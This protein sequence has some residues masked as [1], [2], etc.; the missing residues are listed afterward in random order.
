MQLICLCIAEVEAPI[1]QIALV[2]KVTIIQY[3]LG[4]KSVFFEAYILKILLVDKSCR[5][6]SHQTAV[7]PM[8]I[9]LSGAFF[10]VAISNIAIYIQLD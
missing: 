3:G 10:L 8:R 2:A 7:L 5:P 6:L 4:S 1:K 9:A